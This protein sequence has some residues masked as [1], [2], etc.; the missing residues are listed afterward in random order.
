MFGPNKPNNFTLILRILGGGYLIYLG[1]GLWQGAGGNT[2][3]LLISAFFMLVGAVLLLSSL[4]EI[5]RGGNTEPTPPDDGE[6][7]IKEE[8]HDE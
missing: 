3:Y 2:L 5:S 6:S 4:L 7:E 8:S 1:W